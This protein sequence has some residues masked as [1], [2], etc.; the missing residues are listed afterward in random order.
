M[1][2]TDIRSF[3]R[4]TDQFVVHNVSPMI[5]SV[6]VSTMCDNQSHLP[7]VTQPN[8]LPPAVP[9]LKTTQIKIGKFQF[10]SKKELKKHVASMISEIGDVE[11]LKTLNEQYFLFFIDLCKRHPNYVQKHLANI[12]DFRI[13]RNVMNN[14]F[15]T[16]TVVKNDSSE[17]TIS[18]N[19]CVLGIRVSD[20]KK[21]KESL[22]N[23]IVNQTTEFKR[24]A[25][26]V[27]SKNIF[28]CELCNC[29]LQNLDT[30][31]FHVD[32]VIHFQKL[33][34]DFMDLHPEIEIPTNYNNN[35]YTSHVEFKP[36]NAWIGLLF[37]Q[38]H[39]RH[40][41]LRVLCARCNLTRPHYKPLECSW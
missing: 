28:T 15:K 32:H 19:A 11:S 5:E 9:N 17:C 4:K 39:L 25:N 31:Q 30:T 40:A 12:F 35:S 10:K 38:Y 7:L 1:N 3:F 13:S 33:V 22:R 27:N 18:W 36:E 34:V 26:Q 41:I 14:N 37:A 24:N 20:S 23:S 21:F 16:V 2:Q 8:P 6:V 29:S